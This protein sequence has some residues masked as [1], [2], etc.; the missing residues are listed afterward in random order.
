MLHRSWFSVSPAFVW[1]RRFSNI[2]R[3][4][5]VQIR[6]KEN[7]HETQTCCP[8]GRAP[9]RGSA[10]SGD[11]AGNLGLDPL[12]RSPLLQPRGVVLQSRR[13]LVL[14][15]GLLGPASPSSRLDSRSLRASAPSA[16]VVW[17][18][19]IPL[20]RDYAGRTRS[21]FL[22]RRVIRGCF[23]DCRFFARPVAMG[24]WLRK[25]AGAILYL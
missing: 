17:R 6:T 24:G 14:V 12:Q 10:C 1:A 23:R 15:P 21:L 11:C 22:P 5:F 8:V 25:P 18:L 9:L 16:S 7:Y 20:D 19:R 4:G 13:P 3:P 2:I